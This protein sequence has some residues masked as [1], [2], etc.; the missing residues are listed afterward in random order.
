MKFAL[1]QLKTIPLDSSRPVIISDA[2]EVILHFANIL[3]DYLNTRGM[4]VNFT[5]YSLEG[6]IKYLDSDKPVDSRL[7]KGLIDDYFDKHVETQTMVEG[8]TE[9]LANLSE[10]CDIVI[11][12]NI[13]HNFADR[14]RRLLDRMGL[15]YPMISNSGPKGPILKAIRKKTPEKLIFIDDICHHHKSV[16]QYV[17]DALRI[18]F[19]A[20]SQLNVMEKPSQHSHHRCHDWPHIEQIIREYLQSR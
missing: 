11:L 14:R 6:N 4:Y 3:S 18:Q 5:S 10:L 16:A 15:G 2:D 12:T 7:F 1:E 19:I 17:P 20:D 13:P 9:H 8:A